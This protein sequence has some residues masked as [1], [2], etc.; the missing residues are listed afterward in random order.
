[1]RGLSDCCYV[2]T[3]ATGSVSHNPERRPLAIDLFCGAG[4]LSLGLE[5]AGFDVALAVDRDPLHIATY[6]RNFPQ[7]RA[8]CASVADVSAKTIFEAIGSKSDIDLICGGPPCQ[9]FSH[10][11]KRDL[12]DPRNALLNDF[13]RLVLE[14]RPKAFL[15]ENVPGMSVGAPAELSQRVIA[16]LEGA[17]YVVTRPTGTLN[18]LTFGVPQSRQRI[19]LLGIRRGCGPRISYPTTLVPR[20]KRPTV[21]D[22]IRDLPLL[23]NRRDLFKQDASAYRRSP[24]KALHPFVKAA[25]SI[26]RSRGDRS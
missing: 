22:A 25:R 17:G 6:R 2:P 10:M 8:I 18:A 9:G 19:F 13:V 26:V 23:R 14:L 24:R 16:A 4:G 3:Q 11:G 12:E 1:M 20:A 5:Q 7:F 15:L 21:W